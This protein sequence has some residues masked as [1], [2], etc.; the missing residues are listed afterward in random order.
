MLPLFYVDL[1]KN[2]FGF[3]TFQL[4]Y[5]IDNCGPTADSNTN[6][7]GE[8]ASKINVNWKY[9]LPAAIG[10]AGIIA[11]PFII[12]A[13]GGKRKRKTFKKRIRYKSKN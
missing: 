8:E 7:P 4:S 6:N 5:N 12:A 10:T 11:T 3:S 2:T 1:L 13:L 9:A